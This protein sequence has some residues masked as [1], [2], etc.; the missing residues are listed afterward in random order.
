MPS[1]LRPHQL[2]FA[3]CR[4][5]APRRLA[6]ADAE[7]GP[8]A[9]AQYGAALDAKN[10]KGWTPLSYARAKG[11]YGLCHE[12]GIYPEDVLK[13]RR[14]GDFPPPPSVCVLD[15][16]AGVGPGLIARERG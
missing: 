1:S 16:F 9:G 14:S 13:A 5:R 12:K 6:C 3:P 7:A 11:K 4:L 15:P 8:R 10:P 2:I